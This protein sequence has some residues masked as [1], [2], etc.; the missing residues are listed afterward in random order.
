MN[1]RMNLVKAGLGP[2]ALAEGLSFS[3]CSQAVPGPLPGTCPHTQ[4]TQHLYTRQHVGGEGVG[5]QG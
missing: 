1:G 2:I 5:G 4:S 3:V